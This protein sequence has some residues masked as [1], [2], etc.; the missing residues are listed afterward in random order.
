M[1]DASMTLFDRVILVFPEQSQIDQIMGK[2][3]N[4]QRDRIY[5]GCNTKDTLTQEEMD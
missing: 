4:Q 5:L 2:N 1:L 3:S